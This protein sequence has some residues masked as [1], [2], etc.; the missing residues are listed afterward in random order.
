MD[1][2]L[3]LNRLLQQFGEG[4]KTNTM[5]RLGDLV[6]HQI[7]RLDDQRDLDVNTRGLGTDRCH[8]GNDRTSRVIGSMGTNI[9]RVCCPPSVTLRS[10]TRQPVS[11]W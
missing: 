10:L 7:D 1:R 3:L 8:E 6:L 9:E 2:Y 5:N 4:W 11:R